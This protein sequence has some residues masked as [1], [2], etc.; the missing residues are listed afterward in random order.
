[1]SRIKKLKMGDM[2]K[3]G[4]KKAIVIGLPGESHYDRCIFLDAS[5]GVLV[6]YVSRRHKGVCRWA[7]QE[8]ITYA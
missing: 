1:M 6:M 2:I 3:Y 8:D 5:E 4:G 7:Y